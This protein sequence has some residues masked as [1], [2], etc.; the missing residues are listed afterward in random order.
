MHDDIISRLELW[1]HVC[2]LF[3]YDVCYYVNGMA[4]PSQANNYNGTTVIRVLLLKCKND[5]TLE[6][7]FLLKD[8][9]SFQA[10]VTVCG[11]EKIVIILT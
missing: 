7:H 4:K 6:G 1:R 3:T 2:Y 8:P 9:S 11:L 10:H 5:N